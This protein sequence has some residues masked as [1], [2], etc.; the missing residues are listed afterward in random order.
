MVFRFTWERKAGTG[1]AECS[2][3]PYMPEPLLSPGLWP[4]SRRAAWVL[5]ALQGQMGLQLASTGYQGLEIQ[6]PRPVE[7][8]HTGLPDDWHLISLI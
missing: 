8:T 7:V 5:P 1:P 2:L 3:G 4:H 6:P